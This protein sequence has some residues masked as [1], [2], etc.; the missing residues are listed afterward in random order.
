MVRHVSRY[1]SV[2]V[3]DYD[4]PSGGLLVA[5]GGGLMMAT[6]DCAP[7]FRWCVDLDVLPAKSRW[8]DWLLLVRG[9]VQPMAIVGWFSITRPQRLAAVVSRLRPAPM[10]YAAGILPPDPFA[11]HEFRC[12]SLDELL[13]WA[14]QGEL[15]APGDRL[16]EFAGVPHDPAHGPVEPRAPMRVHAVVERDDADDDTARQ[17]RDFIGGQPEADAWRPSARV[18]QYRASV[19]GRPGSVLDVFD[20]ADEQRRPRLADG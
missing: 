18:N 10:L 11:A 6:M 7:A 16:E 14:S 1:T 13:R 12:R 2:P 5:S 15:P 20:P 8:E 4:R 9:F 19:G 3:I 17:A